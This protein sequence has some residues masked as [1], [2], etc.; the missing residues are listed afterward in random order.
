MW[1]ARLRLDTDIFTST[2]VQ[3]S[4][5]ESA[6]GVAAALPLRPRAACIQSRLPS[7]DAWRPGLRGTPCAP[8]AVDGRWPQRVALVKHRSETPWSSC[9]VPA[10][11]SW[12]VELRGSSV[13]AVRRSGNVAK[14]ESAFRIHA[15][16][17]GLGSCTTRGAFFRASEPARSP[18]PEAA[19]EPDAPADAS[20]R[21]D[22]AAG[23]VR[24]SCAA[25]V[26][27][28]RTRPPRQVGNGE[29]PRPHSLHHRDLRRHLGLLDESGSPEPLRMPRRSTSWAGLPSLVP[30]THRPALK[31]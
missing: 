18:A 4:V 15:G 31:A 24:V 13:T 2:K 12:S 25:C 16:S 21:A 11:P 19:R 27:A 22:L 5:S 17:V 10:S 29:T 30:S 9:L 3:L 20:R 28:D 7:T 14:A 23:R 1:I 26:A 6:P 8:G